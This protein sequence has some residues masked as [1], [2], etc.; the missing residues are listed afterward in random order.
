LKALWK[1]SSE[2]SAN[3]TFYYTL[4]HV[5]GMAAKPSLRYLL[6]D[7]GLS[8]HPRSESNVASHNRVG[9][10]NHRLFND[11]LLGPGL[12]P[13]WTRFEN[14]LAKFISKRSSIAGWTENADFLE[15]FT[16]ELTKVS[17]EALCG[18]LLLEIDPDFPRRFGSIAAVYRISFVAYRASW[19]L[20]RIGSE[21]P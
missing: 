4:R 21:I 6:D 20:S 9:Y 13:L 3:G 8:A 16:L 2:M 10:L 7:S 12:P 19:C 5:F 15:I 18:P 11:L 14:G 1:R 17:L